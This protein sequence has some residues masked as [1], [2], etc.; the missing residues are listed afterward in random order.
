MNNNIWLKLAQQKLGTSEW[1]TID[2]AQ[3]NLFA[4]ATLD[5]QF[6]HVDPQAA[7]KTAF[8][9]TIAHGFLTLS[10]LSHCLFIILKPHQ[11]SNTS[12]INYGIDK[13]RFLNPVKTGK[14]IRYHFTLTSVDE[15]TPDKYL[16]RL[17]VSVEIKGEDKPALLAELLVLSSSN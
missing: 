10:L 1:L 2:Q 12:L 5:H 6:I 14:Q 8:G 4:D 9:G 17:E 7:A 15:K 13:L 3:I 16:L 11:P